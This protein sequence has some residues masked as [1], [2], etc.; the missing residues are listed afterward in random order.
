MNCT[1]NNISHRFKN[2]QEVPIVLSLDMH[3]ASTYALGVNVLT[4]DICID[5]NILGS[6]ETV[7]R[8]LNK[9]NV[10]DKSE[11]LYEAGNHGF[12]PHRLFTKAGYRCRIIAPSSLPQNRRRKVEKTD[13]GDCISNLEYHL[14]GLIRYVTVPDPKTENLRE[15]LRFRYSI[16][17]KVTKQK[18]KVISFTKR[19]GLSYTLT[20]KYWTIKHRQWLKQIEIDASLRCVLNMML[21]QLDAEESRLKQVDTVLENSFKDDQQLL[22]KKYLYELMPGFGPVN[23]MTMILEGAELSRFP[24]PKALMKFTGLVPGKHQSSKSDPAI[25]ITKGGNSFLRLA[26]VGAAKVYRDN[27]TKYSRAALDRMDQPIKDFLVRM[28]ERL[29]GRYEALRQNKKHANKIRCAI[30]REICGF[31][32]EL[33]VKIE[34]ELQKDK[35]LK[36]A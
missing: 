1:I 34:P 13:R 27:R 23:A 7:L 21:D 4:G 11:I 10:R 33:L 3:D 2:A 19:H 35:Y 18:Q 12:H 30:A 15:V 25:G 14:A 24:H 22:W 36:A 16:V 29:F 31:V 20:K 9:L 5:H 32:W 6:P 17:W 28:Q 26:L 8:A